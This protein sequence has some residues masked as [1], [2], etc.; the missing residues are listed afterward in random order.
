MKVTITVSDHYVSVLRKWASVSRTLN[1]AKR[2]I[3][4]VD[5]DSEE[6]DSREAC[7]QELVDLEPSL[8][9]LH[10]AFRSAVWEVE[11][12]EFR[13]AEKEKV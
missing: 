5:P 8:N 13:K 12:A 1:E 3:L 6:G 7:Y 9:A 2:L 4:T 11:D 10:M